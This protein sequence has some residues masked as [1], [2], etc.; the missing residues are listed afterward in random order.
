M[1]NNNIN[2]ISNQY[3]FAKHSQATYQHCRLVNEDDSNLANNATAF[4]KINPPSYRAHHDERK[5][6]SPPA[7][8]NEPL[9]NPAAMESNTEPFQSFI[10]SKR[11]RKSALRG[12]TAPPGTKRGRRG[13]RGRGRD[14]GKANLNHI[15]SPLAYNQPEISTANTSYEATLALA[16]SSGSS[17]S[18]QPKES[19]VRKRQVPLPIEIGST[20]TPKDEALRRKPIY[21]LNASVAV[22]FTSPKLLKLILSCMK[23]DEIVGEILEKTLLEKQEKKD[24]KVLN[25]VCL[26]WA[27]YLHTRPVFIYLQQRARLL[28]QNPAAIPSLLPAENYFVSITQLRYMGPYYRI[29]YLLPCLLRL[30]CLIISQPTAL[31]KD[32]KLAINRTSKA[33]FPPSPFTSSLLP[34][35]SLQYLSAQL[36]NISFSHL[37]YYFSNL[38]NLSLK[39]C[40]V[41]SEIIALSPSQRPF[42][43]PN[44]VKLQLKLL[45]NAYCQTNESLAQ[46]IMAEEGQNVSGQLLLQAKWRFGTFS[47]TWLQF[48]GLEL[49]VGTQYALQQ[50]LF[51]V[52]LP[53]LKKLSLD[54]NRELL[55]GEN[56][57][58]DEQGEGPRMVARHSGQTCDSD[59]PAL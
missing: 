49:S 32:M 55:V 51:Y 25:A 24:K 50:L 3:I 16:P 30:D 11:G 35:T 42:L 6:N 38:A 12:C 10:G 39:Y 53:K 13:G 58:I 15:I 43:F 54:L 23:V 47:N 2:T 59:L 48:C 21:T 57:G 28:Q 19:S 29:F 33:Y 1:N 22:V 18:P 44:L 7:P 41:L 40:S 14:R 17:P 26:Y 34:L 45:N 20:S 46:E 52:D 36:Y 8:M 56:S 5:E 31:D 4:P 37:H 9:I 27:R